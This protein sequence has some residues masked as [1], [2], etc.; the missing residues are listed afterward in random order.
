MQNNVSVVDAIVEKEY[1]S[2]V[3]TLKMRENFALDI[4]KSIYKK[5]QYP[6]NK[7]E[8]EK[9]FLLF[10]DRDGEVERL[11]KI[12]ENYHSF[13]HIRYIRIDGLLSSYYPDFLLKIGEN[14]YFAE[15][16]SQKDVNDLN[17]RQK[18]IS[19]IDFCKKINELQSENRMYSTWSYSI[20][21]DATFYAMK[22]RGASTKDLLEYCK[23]TNAKI[24]GTLF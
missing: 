22:N 23:V 11:L 10:A 7:G 4:K 24:Q 2:Q 8:F 19:A 6:S 18:Q 5:T 15:T 12:N 9:E 21:D 14:I 1:F 17:V 16:K 13:A 20:L 3:S